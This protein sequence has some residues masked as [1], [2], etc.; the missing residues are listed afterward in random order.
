[1][2][3]KSVAVEAFSA[4]AGAGA[5]T[6]DGVELTAVEVFGAEAT[7]AEANTSFGAALEAAG[8]TTGA[9]WR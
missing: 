9:A 8:F 2:K 7:G 5:T 4:A 6:V 3:A 1:M